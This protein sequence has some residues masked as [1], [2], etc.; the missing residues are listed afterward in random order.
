MEDKTQAMPTSKRF[1]S[2]RCTGDCKDVLVLDKFDVQKAGYLGRTAKCKECT[3]GVR[4]IRAAAQTG[5][6]PKAVFLATVAADMQRRGVHYSTM[7]DA[8]RVMTTVL[9]YKIQP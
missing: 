5:S 1:F 3:R 2:K 7:S 8:F 9:G 4:A 6:T